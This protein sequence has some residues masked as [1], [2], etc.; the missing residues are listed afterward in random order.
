MQEQRTRG[1]AAVHKSRA[2]RKRRK[3]SAL[4]SRVFLWIASVFLVWGVL[5][6]K[7][8]QSSLE[9]EKA[10]V[11]EKQRAI[12]ATI[13]PSYEPLRDR[14]EA[15]TME[16]SGPYEGD[17]IDP[18]I[19]D[20]D[21]MQAAGVYL[22]LRI[23][24]ATSVERI[25]EAAQGSLRDGFTACLFRAS[26]PDPTAGPPCELTRD[27]EE[28]LFCSEY[29]RCTKASQPYNM[30]SI[31]RGTR[32]LFDEWTVDLRTTT[33]DMRVRYL[34]GVLDDSANQDVPLAIEALRNAKFFLLVLDEDPPDISEEASAED[35]Q[36]EP[37]AARVYLYGLDGPHEGP[38]LRLRRDIHAQLLTGAGSALLDAETIAAQKR[39]AN[40]CQLALEVRK[41]LEVAAPAPAP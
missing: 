23:G 19:D 25:R 27:C 41:A 8:A 10:R 24:D 39:Q 34:E 15:W 33:N 20:I 29:D 37:H 40:G 7:Y 5:Y 31:Y 2:E 35:V 36:A 9:S 16:A 13:G 26:N 21:F 18:R 30:R 6:Y 3:L 14:I 11:F 1:L 17:F 32:V 12:A 4:P 28:G 22:R 38:L